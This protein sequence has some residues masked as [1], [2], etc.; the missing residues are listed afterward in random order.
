[1]INLL[2]KKLQSNVIHNSYHNI[3]EMPRNKFHQGNNIPLQLKLR[4]TNKESE[5]K[6]NRSWRGLLCIESGGLLIAKNYHCPK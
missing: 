6:K 5:K 3:N 2:R 4:N 1:M